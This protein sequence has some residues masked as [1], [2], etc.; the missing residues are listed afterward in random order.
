MDAYWRQEKAEISSYQLTKSE[1]GKSDT[2]SAVLIF[3]IAYI[4]RKYGNP[5]SEPKKHPGDA[6]EVLKCNVISEFVTG[7][8][9][10]NMMSSTYNPIDFGRYPHCLRLTASSQD[11]S[12]QTFLQMQWKDYRYETHLYPPPEAK[13]NKEII[14]VNTW[15]EDEIWNKIRLAPHQLPMGK[16]EMVP[17]AIYLRLSNARLKVYKAETSIQDLDNHYEYSI[18]YPELKR[19]ISVSFE[20][21]FPYRILDWK[22]TVDHKETITATV[23]KTIQSDYW[24]LTTGDDK[25]IR[26]SLRIR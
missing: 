2:G 8:A 1:D 13:D 9:E 15:L 6:I 18:V 14:L 24:N 12:D 21:A 19:K 26:D 3:K 20:K 17:S 4:S 5:L 25:S 16:I 22:E 11:W 7:I 10:F 23:L